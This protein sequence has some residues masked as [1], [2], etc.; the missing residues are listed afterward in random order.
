LH[1][2]FLE[3]LPTNRLTVDFLC[4]LEVVSF[5]K[6][7]ACSTRILDSGLLLSRIL[8]GVLFK[9]SGLRRVDEIVLFLRFGLLSDLP[10]S[11][12]WIENG[13]QFHLSI[14]ANKFNYLF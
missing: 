14:I 5:L 13:L 6:V 4:K 9:N 2:A 12:V 8:F 3:K 11:G 10:D 1:V 7:L